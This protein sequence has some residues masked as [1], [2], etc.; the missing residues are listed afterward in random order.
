MDE[1][2]YDSNNPTM[3]ENIYSAG[4]NGAPTGWES[5]CFVKKNINGHSNMRFETTE[6]R[7]LTCENRNW[8]IFKT[9]YA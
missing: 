3:T 4:H 1:N 5:N 2:F 6:G 8:E 9:T 7:M